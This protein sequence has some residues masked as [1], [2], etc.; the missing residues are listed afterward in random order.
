M[1]KNQNKILKV[2]TQFLS[3]LMSLNLTLIQLT[4]AKYYFT[5]T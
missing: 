1:T 3:P 5:L 2:P 4:Q